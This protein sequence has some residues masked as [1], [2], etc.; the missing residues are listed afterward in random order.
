MYKGMVLR[1]DAPDNINFG[2]LGA[3]LFS[4]RILI[5]FPKRILCLGAGI[6]QVLKPNVPHGDIFSFFDDPRD[7]FM[8]KYGYGL[9][10]G[11]Y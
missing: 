10:M 5:P 11:W 2:Y 1:F 3:A 6:N 4:K 8:I 7:N 9:Y